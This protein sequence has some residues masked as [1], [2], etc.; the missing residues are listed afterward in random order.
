MGKKKHVLPDNN[1]SRPACQQ[2]DDVPAVAAR[3]LALQLSQRP[4]LLLHDCV[5]VPPVILVRPLSAHLD[6]CIGCLVKQTFYYK[7]HVLG[8]KLMVAAEIDS[9]SWLQS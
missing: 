7:A 4:C 9:V 3:E 6:P 8:Q 5:P 1:G 2:S